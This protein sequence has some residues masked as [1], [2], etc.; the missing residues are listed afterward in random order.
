M[1]LLELLAYFSKL[2]VAAFFDMFAEDVL[3]PTLIVAV[4]RGQEQSVEF[5]V[6]NKCLI[7]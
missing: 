3:D 2:A 7:N 5:A 6:I 1:H 4:L